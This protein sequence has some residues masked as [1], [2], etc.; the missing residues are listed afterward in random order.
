MPVHAKLVGLS[1]KR[2]LTTSDRNA[3]ARC[4]RDFAI[5]LTWVVA[6]L[7]VAARLAYLRRCGGAGCAGVSVRDWLEAAET[8]DPTTIPSPAEAGVAN[9]TRRSNAP[10]PHPAASP[11]TKKKQQQQ[12][13]QRASSFQSSSSGPARRLDVRALSAAAVEMLAEALWTMRTIKGEDGRRRFGPA[14]RSY[15]DLVADHADDAKQFGKCATL[16]EA[17]PLFVAYHRLLLREFEGALEIV[18]AAL[19]SEERDSRPLPAPEKRFGAK[20]K[21]LW[22]PPTMPAWI[23]TAA[24]DPGFAGG[25]VAA[26][27]S[28]FLGSVPGDARRN[29]VVADGRFAFWPV[30]RRD[31]P[32]SDLP[33]FVVRFA[34]SC[35]RANA[36]A[37]PFSAAWR[38]MLSAA[39]SL[40]D[41]FRA[42]YELH[43]RWH[44]AVGGSVR[45]GSGGMP[46]DF[47]NERTSVNDPVF[48]FVHAAFDKAL[49]DFQRSYDA[50]ATFYD[51]DVA[52]G[53]FAVALWHAFRRAID[54]CIRHSY[55]W[56]STH[57]FRHVFLDPDNFK[58]LFEP[59]RKVAN[60][61][62]NPRPRR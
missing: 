49:D 46:G 50:R 16:H 32:E 54:P 7:I 57:R 13:Q 15:E 36:T 14:Y 47:E 58:D 35:A 19:S 52:D 56:I 59:L 29:Y 8:T 40:D 6:T 26:D 51:D 2:L 21:S 25:R 38:T 3:R 10:S 30:A 1:E 5:L 9:E 27:I 37:A 45:C 28:S 17:S 20:R 24:D 11:Q 31:G 34:G 12:Q 22:D 43:S 60:A 48:F 44:R 62:D 18:A 33:A 61:T 41:F 55:A 39:R 4:Q 42:T 23:P 53:P